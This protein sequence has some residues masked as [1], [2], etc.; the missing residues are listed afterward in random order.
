MALFGAQMRAHDLD[1]RSQ[2]LERRIE[3]K[4]TAGTLALRCRAMD[5]FI[6]CRAQ[7]PGSAVVI[8]LILQEPA[9]AAAADDEKRTAVLAVRL[10]READGLLKAA[11]MHLIG[12]LRGTR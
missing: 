7:H 8:D 11:Q 3:V 4:S 1:R 10:Q 12:A 2:R 9:L 6:S 5:G